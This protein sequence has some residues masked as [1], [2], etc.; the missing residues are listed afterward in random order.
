[1]SHLNV[2]FFTIDEIGEGYILFDGKG[3]H[4]NYKQYDDK[5]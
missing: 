4:L 1:M 5:A 2:D 3:N